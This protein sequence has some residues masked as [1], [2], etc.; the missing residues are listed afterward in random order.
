[1]FDWHV[2][3]PIQTPLIFF[4]CGILTLA[5][6]PCLWS[7]VFNIQSCAHDLSNLIKY[8]RQPWLWPFVNPYFCNLTTSHSGCLVTKLKQKV[9]L[10]SL[11][12]TSNPTIK[13]YQIYDWT[14]LK[15]TLTWS[16]GRALEVLLHLPCFPEYIILIQTLF[17]SSFSTRP[18]K[19]EI[20]R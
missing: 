6:L 10:S 18:S 3:A 1:M 4:L 17:H 13:L 19:M 7:S 14:W 8:T 16:P 2:Y 15:S 9:I 12:P 5:L 20:H 11:G